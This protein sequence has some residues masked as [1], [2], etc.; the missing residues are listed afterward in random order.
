[1]DAQVRCLACLDRLSSLEPLS[2]LSEDPAPGS[3][4]H[5]RMNSND[6]V[7]GALDPE[8][9]PRLPPLQ[10]ALQ[11][12]HAWGHRSLL[13]LP[14]MA[15]VGSRRCSRQGAA[16]AESF[17]AEAVRR[18]L[19][20]VSGLA[21]GIDAAAHEGAQIQSAQI[22]GAQIGGT[23]APAGC[24][25]P[26]IAVLGSG[27][28]N[29]YPPAHRALAQRIVEGGG[30]LLSEYPPAMPALRHHFPLRNRLIAGLSQGV[31]IVEAA[32]KSGA[33]ITAQLAMEL[34]RHVWVLPGSVHDDR[35]AGSHALIRQG[36][37]LV[38]SPEELFDDWG[39]WR[40]ARL[41]PADGEAAL[42]PA[43]GLPEV[44]AQG[45][46]A[47]DRRILESLSWSPIDVV[48]VMGRTE[49]SHLD[50]RQ[51]L[52]RLSAAGLA[53]EVSDGAWARFKSARRYSVAK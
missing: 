8:Q 29:I 11:S 25:W 33:L 13:S 46:A 7:D 43:P 16:D 19:V 41:D 3:R 27:I 48:S 14:A 1:M 2:H 40:T 20:V 35:Y 12:L 47:S 24:A 39:L 45:L 32:A 51:G 9:W 50:C 26:T 42:A 31:L 6:L 15:I 53:V 28:G 30:L 49:L 23:Q 18:G 22:P 38:S 21:R 34:G 36:A 17:A 52:L 4:N 44:I 37:S 5:G 10:P